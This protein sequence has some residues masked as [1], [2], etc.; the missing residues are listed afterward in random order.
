MNV[1]VPAC[2]AYGV[3]VLHAPGR[4]A[5]AVADLTLAMLLMLAR[6]LPAASG[7]LRQPG[8]E[9][10][11]MG[12]MGKAFSTL[13]GAELWRK[14]VGLVGLGAVGRG[15]ARRLAGFGARVLVSDPFVDPEAAARLGAESVELDRLLAESDFVSLHAAVSDAT[16]GLLGADA[17][18]RMKPGSFLVNTARAALLDEEALE[19]ALESG[20]LAGAALDAFGIEPPGSDHPLLA[21]ESVIATPHIGG[22]TREVAAH[23]GRIVVDALAALLRGER[24]P[25]VL[26]APALDGFR[27]DRARRRPSAEEL[28]AL[29][30]R[31]APAVSDLDRARK[32]RA[33]S[34]GRQAGESAPAR[35]ESAATG[36]AAGAARAHMER[37][38]ERFVSGIAA[39]EALSAFAADQDVR[40][41]FRLTDLGL[42][43]HFGL[44]DGRV[45]AALGAPP[46]TAP[47]AMRM[48]AEI[49]H[50]MFSGTGNPMQAAMDGKLSFTGDAAKAM[51]LQQMQRD[52]RRI[53][54]AACAELGEPPDLSAIGEPGATAPAA[55]GGSDALR[56]QLVAVV[57]E[58]YA[59]Q[60]ITATGGNVSVRIPGTDTIWITP[61]Q[62]FKGELSPELLV[63]IDLEGQPLDPEARSPS[64][65]WLMHTALYRARPE[66]QA[67]IH[68]HAP[69]AT[70]LANAGLPF[71]PISTEAAFFGE[72]ARLPFVMPGTGELADAI[73]EAIGRDWAV[74]MQN[75]G[76]LVAGRRLRRTADM[77]EIVERSAEVI[78]GCHAVGREP[79][80][81]PDDVVATLRKMGDLVA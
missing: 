8:I 44:Q 56:E 70:I 5:D 27:W 76:I 51:S 65:E 69:H 75:H 9:A 7:F 43:F 61:S 74:L 1:D 78:L 20:H 12:R 73:V 35:A 10:G 4:N 81:L 28:A 22:N 11:D 31:A 13:Q 63:R 30:E 37:L 21:L 42:E 49:L 39:D 33:R 36:E 45:D 71:V 41:H 52:L 15:V 59:A 53:Y 47:V 64:S 16:T 25:A 68:A 58:L 38:L 14:T 26:N 6:K 17:F 23:Q 50:G 24:P 80:T 32:Q 62:L 48:P 55:A 19:D 40:L 77:V 72:I 57:D 54:T 67:V 46:E 34:R 79:P 3:P 66:I 2:T 60:V 29:A 18:A